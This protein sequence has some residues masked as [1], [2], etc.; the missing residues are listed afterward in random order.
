MDMNFPQYLYRGD[1]DGAG[2]RRLR[3]TLHFGQLQTNLINGGIG[4]EITEIPLTELINRHVG[5]G[6]DKTHFLSFSACER[7]AFRFGMRCDVAHLDDEIDR[8]IPSEGDHDW[9]FV[10]IVIDTK[11]IRLRRLENGVYEGLYRP[12]LAKFAALDNYRI[13]L[14][15]VVRVLEGTSAYLDSLENAKR[16]EEW[17][18]LPATPVPFDNAVE[19]SAI[20]DGNCISEVKRYKR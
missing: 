19:Y 2:S 12:H 18:I 20:L 15:D 10:I 8:C 7:T 4:R 11:R 1:R 17:L 3:P 9:E 13:I 6:W 14:I 16:D 5:F